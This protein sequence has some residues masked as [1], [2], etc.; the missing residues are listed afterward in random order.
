MSALL[1]V[2]LLVPVAD[3]KEKELSEAGK[4]ELKKLEGK[5]KA[6]EVLVEGKEETPPESESIVEFKGRKFLL[7][8][9]ELFDVAA[10]DPSTA[11]KILDFKALRDMGE[12]KKDTTYE[13][14]YK[15]DGDTLVVAL[16]IGE[17]SKRPDK[18]ESAKD[19]KVVVV[20]FKKEK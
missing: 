3:A 5:W 6:T 2:L 17:G 12:I 14:I 8:G 18:F 13:G 7:G 4:K 9:N 20:T 16:Y 19:S 1:A 11:P 15:L 10:L